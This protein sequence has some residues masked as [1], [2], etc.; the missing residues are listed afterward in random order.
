MAFYMSVILVMVESK[1]FSLIFYCN[2]PHCKYLATVFV[3]AH[4]KY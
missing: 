4:L 3:A 2:H 1:C